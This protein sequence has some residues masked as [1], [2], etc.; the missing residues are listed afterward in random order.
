MHGGCLATP[1]H[2]EHGDVYWSEGV[3]DGGVPF[4]SRL[5]VEEQVGHGE[6]NDVGHHREGIPAAEDTCLLAC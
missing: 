6:H 5:E 2:P 4:L 1:T 3:A